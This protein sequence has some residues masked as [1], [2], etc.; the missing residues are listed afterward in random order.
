M[1]PEIFGCAVVVFQNGLYYTH[2]FICIHHLM[3]YAVMFIHFN[4]A[5]RDITTS[6]MQERVASAA[7]EAFQDAIFDISMKDVCLCTQKNF[8]LG[9]FDKVLY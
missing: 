5:T 4:L 7:R 6:L 3:G 2:S 8:V 9:Y 1:E